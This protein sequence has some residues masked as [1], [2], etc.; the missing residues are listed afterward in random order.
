MIGHFRNVSGDAVTTRCFLGGSLLVTFRVSLG[1]LSPL[2]PLGQSEF[3]S[4]SSPCSCSSASTSSASASASVAAAAPA[5]TATAA[6]AAAAAPDGNGLSCP[7][8]FVLLLQAI[9]SDRHWEKNFFY[10]GK[11]LDELM[12]DAKGRQ[13]ASELA[14]APT[15]DRLDGKSKVRPPATPPPPPPPPSLA[16]RSLFSV[17]QLTSFLFFIVS[18]TRVSAGCSRG[19][20]APPRD[21]P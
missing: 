3:S 20:A 12:E 13:T 18:P 2:S 21:P 5:S 16:L 9:R 15:K 14:S 6:A 1:H 19:G 8:I 17:P 10:L 7:V 4:S 11:Y